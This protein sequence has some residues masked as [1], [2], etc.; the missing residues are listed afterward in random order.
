MIN[1]VSAQ[2]I[3][4]NPTL[5]ITIKENRQQGLTAETQDFLR[6]GYKHSED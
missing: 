6:W 2:I 1:H 4:T 5:N 3:L